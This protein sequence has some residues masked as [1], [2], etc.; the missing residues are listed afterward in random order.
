MK[1]LV[2]RQSHPLTSATIDRWFADIDANAD[3]TSILVILADLEGGR[4][5]DFPNDATAY[6]QRDALYTIAAYAVGLLPYPDDAVKFLNGMVK[7][8]T[9]AQPDANFGVYPGYVDPLIPSTQWPQQYWGSN[10][11]RLKQIKE[12]YDPNHVFS[13]PQSVG[14]EGVPQPEMPPPKQTLV[15]KGLAWI[16][17]T[18]T[19]CL[20]TSNQA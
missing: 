7:T 9:D 11:P 16:R 3:N 1:S 13:N 12:T 2:V 10:Y 20:S 4:I 19:S 18:L 14:M 15:G 17:K 8:I 5:S 6:A